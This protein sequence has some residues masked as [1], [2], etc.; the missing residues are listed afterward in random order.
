MYSMKSQPGFVLPF[1]LVML[2]LI[3]SVG[4]GLVLQSGLAFNNTIRFSYNQIA[5]VASKAAIDYAEEQY[6]LDASY[7]G[8]AEQNLVVTSKY[9]STIEVE[10]LQNQGASAKR[11]RAYGRVYIPQD[12]GDNADFTREIQATIIRNGEVAGNPADYEPALWLDA[13]EPD[14]LFETEIP[15]NTQ[16]ITGLYGTTNKDIVE[17]RGSDANGSNPGKTDFG[18]NDIEM[19]WDGNARGH[20]HVGLRFRNVNVPKNTTIDNAYVQFTASSTQQTGSVQLRMRGIASDNAPQWNGN[21]AVSN[22]TKTTA[23][24]TWTPPNWNDVGVAGADE[25]VDV[26]AIVQELVNRN[27]WSANNAMAFAVSWI[28]GSGIRTAEKGNTGTAPRL[29]IQWGSGSGG[30]L[31]EADGD[32]VGTWLDKSGNNNDAQRVYGSDGTLEKD[33]INGLDAVRVPRTTVFLSSLTSTLS[34]N[35]MTAF[36]VMKPSSS[37]TESNGRFLTAMRSTQSNDNNTLD[38]IVMMYRSNSSS[39]MTQYYNNDSGETLNNAVDD[40]WSVFSSRISSLYAERLLENGTD[41]YS[42]QISGVNYNVNQIYFGGRRSV[43]SATQLSEMDVAEIIVY[44]RALVCDQIQQVENYLG[45][46]Y[47]ITIT[48]KNCA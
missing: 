18:G 45:L 1:I 30:G 47:D 40:N 44:D 23:Q 9:R 35:G 16:T 46:R 6:E 20:Q 3:S 24:T 37:N 11:V 10:I 5:H 48:N 28:Q 2:V 7:D 29:F 13:Q 17:E 43:S 21:Y 12:S 19:S 26:T 33:E 39:T 41:N 42:E 25:R 32:A 4:L 8:T 36:M 38:G 15:P 14:S 22:A 31:A 27:G 34:D